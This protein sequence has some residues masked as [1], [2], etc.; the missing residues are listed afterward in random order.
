VGDHESVEADLR[1]LVTRAV[2]GRLPHGVLP[3]N[4][5]SVVRLIF[6]ALAQGFR[7]IVLVGIDLDTRPHFWFDPQ[8]MER[9]PEYVA[10]FPEPDNKHHGTTESSNRALGNREFLMIFSRVLTELGVAKLW[11]SSPTSQLAQALPLYPWP[12]EVD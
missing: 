9:Y 4:G 11:I 10:L 2:S 5:S 3:D 8:Y 1:Y 12:T 6:F 7:D